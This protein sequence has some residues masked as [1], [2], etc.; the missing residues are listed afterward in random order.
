MDVE[1]K[2]YA[3]FDAKVQRSKPRFV[4]LIQEVTGWSGVDELA[5]WMINLLCINVGGGLLSSIRP[6]CY[7][8]HA[9]LSVPEYTQR[10]VEVTKCNPDD[11]IIQTAVAKYAD[12]LRQ[13]F[14]L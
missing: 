7:K 1:G 5:D 2:I 14:G 3:D 9:P 11:P 4:N 13:R 8:E 10:L 12:E 6:P